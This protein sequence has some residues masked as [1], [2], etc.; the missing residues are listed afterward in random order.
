MFIFASR[1]T[2][3][4]KRLWRQ[5][6][7]DE[8][9]AEQRAVATALLK[10]LKE[11]QLEGL[12]QA[13]EGSGREAGPCC[14]VPCGNLRLGRRGAVSPQVLTARLLRWPE[15]RE[16]AELVLSGLCPLGGEEGEGGSV[17]CNPWHW[18]RRLDS[19]Q[20]AATPMH[21]SLMGVLS[22]V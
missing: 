2:G 4:L 11:P 20:P 15:V 14:R 7:R 17:C 6:P 21:W 13:A 12:V 18:A 19:G 3:L 22:G 16:E 9:V 1:R 5:Q 8:A 10:R